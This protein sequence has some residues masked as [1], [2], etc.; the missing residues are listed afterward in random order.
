MERTV[1]IVC[2]RIILLY[3]QFISLKFT[4]YTK[5]FYFSHRLDHRVTKLLFVVTIFY[6]YFFKTHNLNFTINGFKLLA[7]HVSVKV[8]IL[9]TRK[10]M[11][12][13]FLYLYPRHN[14]VTL[15]PHKIK[16]FTFIYKQ[17]NIV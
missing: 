9:L 15:I 6:F 8:E 2:E 3:V 4:F 10:I 11:L 7:L 1:P 14:R 16:K 17:L 12:S 13:F 5:Y